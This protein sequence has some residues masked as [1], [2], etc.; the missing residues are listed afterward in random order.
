MA[1]TT[2]AD[3]L[4]DGLARAGAA[5]VFVSPDAPD[6]LR[7]AARRRLQVVEASD[8]MAAGLLAAVTGEVGDGPGAMLAGLDDVSS[9][10]RGLAH[11]QRDRAPL[12]VLTDGGDDIGLLAPAVKATL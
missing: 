4:V 8:V 11:A 10:V 2:V 12:I 5:R 1:R 6:G 3:V 9:I 7:V